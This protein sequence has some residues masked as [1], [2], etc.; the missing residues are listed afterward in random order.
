[1]AAAIQAIIGN[2]VAGSLF[3]IAQSIAMGGAAVI[4]ILFILACAA[5]IGGLAMAVVVFGPDILSM[6]KEAASAMGAHIGPFADKV[7]EAVTSV[8]PGIIAMGKA[9]AAAIVEAIRSMVKMST[10]DL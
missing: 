7:A 2:V 5:I 9:A 8:G 10:K 4:P 6:C 3:A 1:L